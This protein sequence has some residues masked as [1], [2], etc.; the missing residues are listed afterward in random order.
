M[1]WNDNLRLSKSGYV[2]IV[3][4]LFNFTSSCNTSRSTSFDLRKSA[5]SFPSLPKT[6]A[7]QF[8]KHRFCESKNIYKSFV[9]CLNVREVSVPVPVTNIR[10]VGFPLFIS[11]DIS[12]SILVSASTYFYAKCKGYQYTR[13]LSLNYNFVSSKTLCV[14]FVYE[15]ICVFF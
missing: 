1:F 12:K 14:T 9:Y 2:K 3:T 15:F 7:H 13:N 11:A 8:K 10:V 5:R 4:S 6:N